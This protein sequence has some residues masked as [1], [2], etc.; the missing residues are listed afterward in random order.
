MCWGNWLGSV[1]DGNG[2]MGEAGE[3]CG[4]VNIHNNTVVYAFG[5]GGGSSPVSLNLGTSS[6][7]GGYP[8]AGIGGGG[9][10]GGGGDWAAGA[11]GYCGSIGDSHDGTEPVVVNGLAST[12]VG[13]TGGAGS[14]YFTAAAL[15]QD[16]INLSNQSLNPLNVRSLPGGEGGHYCQVASYN[17]NT[18]YGPWFNPSTGGAAGK[19]GEL[20][21][22]K[23][24]DIYAFNGD[25]ITNDD[26]E[27]IA[28]DYSPTGEQLSTYCAVL[29]IDNKKFIETKIYAQQGI[30]REIKA[31]N[32]TWGNKDN[33]NLDYFTLML[34]DRVTTKCKNMT[35]AYYPEDIERFTVATQT[36]CDTTGYVNP[37]TGLSYGIGSGAG[38]I[39]RSNG[40]YTQY[41]E[42][43]NGNFTTI[44]TG[45]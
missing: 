41:N 23:D 19:G 21:C 10:G 7:A 27:T 24:V 11:G 13:A 15:S 38:Y 33:S 16:Q 9:A 45:E 37:T 8:A 34:G 3:N 32:V 20:K 12:V 40:T 39:E 4:K 29:N 31:T 36:T 6:G 30:L 35:M 2:Y 43:S 44:Y 14:S 25:R 1:I 26:Y 28:Y 5:G 22:G 42:D 18:I 17:G